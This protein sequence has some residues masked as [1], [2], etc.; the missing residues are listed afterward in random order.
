MSTFTSS[1]DPGSTLFV[2]WHPLVYTMDHP[3]F[4]VSSQKEESISIHRV[5]NLTSK[6]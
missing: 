3:K 1:E 4:I 2:T 5:N 6:Q